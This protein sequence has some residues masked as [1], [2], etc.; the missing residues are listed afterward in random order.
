MKYRGHLVFEYYVKCPV[1]R[2]YSF[3]SRPAEAVAK[4]CRP[5]TYLA[6]SDRLHRGYGWGF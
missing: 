2:Q 5:A 1:Q 3:G 6:H 4:S